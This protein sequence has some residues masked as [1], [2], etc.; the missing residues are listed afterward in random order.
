MPCYSGPSMPDVTANINAQG[1]KLLCAMARELY[2][3]KRL[4]ENPELR[5]WFMMHLADDIYGARWVK[6]HEEQKA[7][8]LAILT[9]LLGPNPP[10]STE[11]VAGMKDGFVAYL[12]ITSTGDG[13]PLHVDVEFREQTTGRKR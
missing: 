4:D 9:D 1:T 8:D 2:E 11:Y 6:G 5:T 7:K 12:V 3:A 13:A 10:I